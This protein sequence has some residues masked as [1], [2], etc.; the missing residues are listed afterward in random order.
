M[1][2]GQTLLNMME[3]LHP[4]LQLQPGE[5][6]VTKGL[7][8]LN[9]AQDYMESLLALQPQL[10]GDTIGTITATA[11]NEV[12]QFP[13]SVLRL[14]AIQMLN[15]SS[16]PVY[17]LQPIR[18]TGGHVTNNDV[19]GFIANGGGA[20]GAPTAYWTDG[21]YIFWS[22]KPDTSYTL[23]WYGFQA[24]TDLTANGTFLY[25]D[26][27]MLPMATAAVRIYRTG[28]DDD[29]SQ[30]AKLGQDLFEPVIN[31]LSNFSRERAAGFKY[32]YVHE[33]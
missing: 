29:V 13:A 32:R 18:D 28:L 24:A 1:A 9:A 23:R 25:Q 19:L 3:V 17:D 11:N 33:T 31:L 12:T 16:V 30:Y 27:C 20:T 8:A 7:L 26:V 21:S 2:T 14:D 6:D 22:P 4:E 10:K 5:A 15:A